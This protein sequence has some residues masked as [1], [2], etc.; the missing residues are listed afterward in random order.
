MG[1]GWADL[2]AGF[3]TDWNADGFQDL[4]AQWND[5]ALRVYYGSTSPFGGYSVVGNG[6]QGWKISV[7]HWKD[8]DTYPSIVAYDSNGALRHYENPSGGLVGAS[9]QIGQGWSGLEIVQMDFDK[10]THTDI[11]AKTPNGELA[12]YRSNGS[13]SFVP[14]QPWVIGAGW[15]VITAISPTS[16]FAGA[17]TTGMLARTSGGDLRYYPILD[18]AWGSPA[19]VGT[20]WSP[21]KI[22][23][24]TMP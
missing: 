16:G 18:N 11:V 1:Y 14:E 22:F 21:L 15:D 2:N 3:V 19:T 13:G 17:G 10:D 5:G 8:G 24:S 6:W 7:G 12:L 23:R 9:T 4:L 20:G